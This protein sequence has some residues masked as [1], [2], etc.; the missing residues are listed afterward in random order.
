MADER[1]ELLRDNL[2]AMKRRIATACAASGRDQN[3][4]TL[5][6]VT[7]Y[8]PLEDV[9]RLYELGVRDFGESRPQALWER[10]PQLPFDARW[11]MI[12]RFQTNKARR[13]LPLVSMV[14]SVDRWSL[15]ETLSSLSAERDRRLPVTIQLNLTGEETKAGFA[16][17]QFVE[18][19]GR[20]LELPGL[21]I[22]GLMTMAK[23]EEEVER[24]RATFAEL[25]Q[26]RERLGERRALPV[27]S[28][29]MSNDFD[30]AVQE[31][32]THVRIG[33]ALFAEPAT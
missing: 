26:L 32:A 15:A 4:V 27:L 21:D 8:A 6:A 16:P 1:L 3:E 33:S 23:H 24:C 29:G 19:F 22:V 25:R 17:E 28:M 7:K 10:H 31:G 18:E 30:I 5:V 11:H 14:H 12:G 20:L 13:T 9:R 2:A